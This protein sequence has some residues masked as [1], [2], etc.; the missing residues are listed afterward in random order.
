MSSWAEHN[1]PSAWRSLAEPFPIRTLGDASAQGPGTPASHTSSLGLMW[2]EGIT[3]GLAVT[4]FLQSP[5]LLTLLI[6]L[7]SVGSNLSSLVPLRS[8]CPKQWPWLL[9]EKAGSA[10]GTWRAVTLPWNTASN[11]PQHRSLHSR[12]AWVVCGTAGVSPEECHKNYWRAG[13]PLL[14]R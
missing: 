13:T 6:K 11:R 4:Q 9:Q 14:W 3:L 7:R 2:A 1:V 10:L 8:H 5:T 12:W